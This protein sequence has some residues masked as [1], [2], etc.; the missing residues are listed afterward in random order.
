MEHGRAL[1]LTGPEAPCGNIPILAH[2]ETVELELKT[3]LKS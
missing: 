3:G 2:A 1:Q